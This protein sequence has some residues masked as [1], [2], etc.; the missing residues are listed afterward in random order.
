[1]LK[2]ILNE[3]G[4]LRLKEK[5]KWLILKKEVKR[6]KGL[7]NKKNNSVL[8]GRETVRQLFEAMRGLIP[9][10]KK[11]IREMRFGDLIGFPIFE[12]PNKFAFYVVDI[13]NTTNMTLECPMGDIVITPKTVKQVLGLQMG[14]RRLER[15]GQR[16]YNDP[17][18]LQ[19]K[20]QFRN[21]NKLTIK[22]LLDVIIETKPLIICLG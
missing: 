3:K 20:D 8:K 10:R 16:E 17:F 13:L 2:K 11:V 4:K 18:L 9:E 14:R 6:I 1:M 15:E 5:K 19:W 12:I 7:I 21:V 22:A